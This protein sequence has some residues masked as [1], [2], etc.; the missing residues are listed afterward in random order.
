MDL[1]KKLLAILVLVEFIGFNCWLVAIL[2]GLEYQIPLVAW[3]ICILITALILS[4]VKI[5]NGKTN[6]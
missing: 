5:D 2:P 1:V 6:S 4:M 3:C